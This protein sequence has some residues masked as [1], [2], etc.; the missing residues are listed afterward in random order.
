MF[1]LFGKISKMRYPGEKQ[2][3]ATGYIVKKQMLE[4]KIRSGGVYTREQTG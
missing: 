2:E 1:A 3:Q 4:I